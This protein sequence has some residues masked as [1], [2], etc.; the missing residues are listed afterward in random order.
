MQVNAH[1]FYHGM[2][3]SGNLVGSFKEVLV[4]FD[5]RPCSDSL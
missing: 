1:H 3:D 5:P 2:K 4:E